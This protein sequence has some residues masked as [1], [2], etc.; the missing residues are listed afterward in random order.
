MPFEFFT[1]PI[2]G[3]VRVEPKVYA[4]GRGFFM[5]SY[6][7]SDF[8]ANG[9][10]ELFVQ[11]NHSRSSQGVLRGLH[12]QLAPKAQGKL[13]RA[14]IG[15]V[16]DVVVDLRRGS[17]TYSRWLGME[18][19]DT[20]RSL[21]Y[22]PPGFAHGFYVTSEIAEIEYWTTEE[23]A[24]SFEGGIVWNDPALGIVWPDGQP[25]LSERDRRWPSLRE[26]EINFDFT[27]KNE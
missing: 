3:V 14:L 20:S 9:I 26:A 16:F 5:E 24:A 8:A 2:P 22:I 11:S 12:Y 19:S 21:I 23:Y 25:Q 27:A 18:L 17:P 4:D 7:H 10:A 15:E 1:T 6:K 13:V